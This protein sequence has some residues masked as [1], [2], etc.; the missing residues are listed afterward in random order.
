VNKVVTSNTDYDTFRQQVEGLLNPVPHNNIGGDFATNCAPN[1]NL[2]FLHQSYVDY[3]WVQWQAKNGQAFN[4]N[5]A[6]ASAQCQGLPYT[7]N[8]VLD[9]TSLCYEYAP[10]TN[11]NLASDQ[12]PSYTV[13]KPVPGVQV[14]SIPAN[15]TVRCSSQ[16][17]Q[18]LNVLR[19][20]DET[21]AS[22]CQASGIDVNY[23]RGLENTYRGVHD[24]LNNIKGYTSPCGLWTRSS[25]SQ[26]LTTSTQ[27]FYCDVP[28]FGRM[29]IAT[30]TGGASTQAVTG[31][32][33]AQ[34]ISNVHGAASLTSGDVSLPADSY[35]A[36]V[37]S[38]VGPS[39]F[40]GAGTMES[41][42]GMENFNAGSSVKAS[43]VVTLASAM[44]MMVVMGV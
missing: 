9:H 29:Q 21:P 31:P 5:G 35:R 27:S 1:D 32:N 8:Q 16:D 36:Q 26:P 40:P 28:S 12:L 7:V 14:V 34:L 11:E 41:I 19:Y 3:M 33:P 18:N 4:G 23:V 25:L 37:Q 39:A 10:L 20:A 43:V 15:N 2:Y 38:I 30:S 13:A 42:T 6:S 24:Q 22:W 17:R 44:V